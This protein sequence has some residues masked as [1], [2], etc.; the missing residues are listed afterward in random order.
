[1]SSLRFILYV[2]TP[3]PSPQSN[4]IYTAVRRLL[5]CL[6]RTNQICLCNQMSGM[7]V[8][9]SPKIK[10]VNFKF[11]FYVLPIFKSAYH[12]LTYSE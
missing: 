5:F 1:M 11:G 9:P 12:N 8:V 10:V 2:G 7:G 4:H 3:P 6:P